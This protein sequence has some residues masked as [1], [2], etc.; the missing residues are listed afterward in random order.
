MALA[1]SSVASAGG[2]GVG[3]EVRMGG[4]LLAIERRSN[5]NESAMLVLLIRHND[6]K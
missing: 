5:D 3:E 1:R 2:T 6:R 4:V